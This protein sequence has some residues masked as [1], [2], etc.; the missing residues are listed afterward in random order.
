LRHL[1]PPAG[2]PELHTTDWLGKTRSDC[3]SARGGRIRQTHG[4]GKQ[5]SKKKERNE[6]TGSRSERKGK[7]IELACAPHRRPWIQV[8]NKSKRW[9]I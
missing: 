6:Q 9:R 3:G 4:T 5:S 7:G 2:G 8:G 1:F